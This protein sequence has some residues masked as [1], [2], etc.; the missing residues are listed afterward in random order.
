MVGIFL[1]PDP[2]SMRQPPVDNPRKL[3]G[4]CANQRKRKFGRI[5]SVTKN[6]LDLNRE[7]SEKA[8]VT[9]PFPILTDHQTPAA[10]G[11]FGF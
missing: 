7:I 6:S 4:W 10:T 2:V 5:P 11:V 9:Q 3:L 8:A 1:P